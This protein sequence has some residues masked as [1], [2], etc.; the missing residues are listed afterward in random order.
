MTAGNT[1]VKM[2][3]SSENNK[4]ILKNTLLLYVR[5]FFMMIVSLYTSR[6]ILKSLGV[7]DFGIYNVVGGVV[8]MMGV[9]NG[10]MA[11]ATQRYLTYELGNGNTKRLNEVFCMC[12]NIYLVLALLCVLVSET[13]GLWFLN[14]QLVIPAERMYAANWV[15]QLSLLTFLISMLTNPYNAVIVS[16]EKMGIYAYI[17]IFEAMF[18]LA[19]VFIVMFVPYD[20]LI[21]YGFLCM[22]SQLIVCGCYVTYCNRHYS[23]S[24]YSYYWEGALFKNLSS[25]LGW[26]LFG[27]MAT[28]A[29]GQG[30]NMLLNMFFSPVVNAAR[31][32][33]YQVSTTV[34]NF[35]TN[36]YTAVRPQITKYYAQND[37]DNMFRLVFKSS[38]MSFFLILFVSLPLVVEAPYVIQLWLG[39]RPDYVVPFMRLIITLTAVDAMATPLMTTAHATGKIALYQ[40]VVGTMTTLNIPVSY[41]LL[42]FAECGPVV[43]F[44]VSVCISVINLFLR[45]WIVKRLVDFP[46]WQ[47]IKQIFVKCVVVTA[48]ACSLP[49]CLHIYLEESFLSFVAVCAVTL[50]SSVCTIYVIGLQASE[51]EFVVRAVKTK[52]HIK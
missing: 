43:V 45:L 26:N 31:G 39:Q 14:T 52:L 6:V 25:Y 51:R 9:I 1:D 27:S 21:F 44:Q 40:F 23:E 30:L 41:C 33:A 49:I 47:Y 46:V 4:R 10:S 50:L 22:M 15:F 11:T 37:M 36:F 20:K 8:S 28:L 38:K 2:A 35:F 12:V 17:S 13:V 42:K 29:K 5:M 48:V 32:I 7:V 16:R 24:H 34:Y 18:K 3:N 19:I